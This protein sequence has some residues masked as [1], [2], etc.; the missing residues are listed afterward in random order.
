MGAMN[1]YGKLNPTREQPNTMADE[2]KR[3]QNI[4]DA[5]AKIN[6]GA[7]GLE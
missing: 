2:A 6:S 1:Y 7:P 3:K 4:A 5:L